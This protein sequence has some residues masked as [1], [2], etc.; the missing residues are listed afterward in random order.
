M[1]AAVFARDGFRCQAAGLDFGECFGSLTPHHLLKAS[2]GG[3][4]TVDNLLT[5]CSAH[6]DRVE[7]YPLRARQ[8]GLVRKS[9]ERKEQTDGN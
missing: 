9:R 7:D 1:L 2:Q 4:Y 5:L 8:L 3:R 6:N